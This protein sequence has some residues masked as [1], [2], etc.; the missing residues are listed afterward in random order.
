MCPTSNRAEVFKSSHTCE[1]PETRVN[2]RNSADTLLGVDVVSPRHGCRRY[3]PL[4]S[5]LWCV[6]ASEVRARFPLPFTLASCIR[7]ACPHSIPFVCTL[8]VSVFKLQYNARSRP[9][10]L[11]KPDKR[12]YAQPMIVMEA[13]VDIIQLACNAE[14]GESY[15]TYLA[16]S[17]NVDAERGSDQL[18]KSQSTRSSCFQRDDLL[19]PHVFASGGH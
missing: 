10:P 4:G 2:A 13:L 17:L 16:H 14:S 8:D 9:R 11:F 6:R 7:F 1:A 3:D 18:Y 5:C 15:F 19:D 12:L